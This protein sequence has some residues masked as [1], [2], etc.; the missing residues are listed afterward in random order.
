[1]SELTSQLF[2]RKR[3]APRGGGVSRAHEG[4]TGFPP[5]LVRT[6]AEERV[7]WIV[8]LGDPERLADAIVEAKKRPRAEITAMGERARHA[9]EDKYS[10]TAAI[11]R[12]RAALK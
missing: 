10:L 12:Y 2:R 5:R 6:H 7:G 9:A 4:D 3:T 1:M 11:E 8:P